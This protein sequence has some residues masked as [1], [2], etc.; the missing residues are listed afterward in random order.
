MSAT[1]QIVSWKEHFVGFT[2]WDAHAKSEF[3]RR[4][5]RGIKVSQAE[6]RHLAR[7]VELRESLQ[8]TGVDEEAVD[9]LT[10]MLQTMGAILKFFWKMGITRNFSDAFHADKKA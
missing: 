8:L 7:R 10:Q 2:G 6:I 1:I 5:R 9:G 3:R 4:L